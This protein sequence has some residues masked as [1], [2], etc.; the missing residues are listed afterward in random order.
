MSRARESSQN[1]DLATFTTNELVSE[2]MA[3]CSAVGESIIFV[4]ESDSNAD[5]GL[6][7][8]GRNCPRHSAI[9]LVESA[10][11]I[12]KHELVNTPDVEP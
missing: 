11:A 1:P 9:G 6:C 2:I 12:W 3:R 5:S 10:S 4:R 7:A 8:Y